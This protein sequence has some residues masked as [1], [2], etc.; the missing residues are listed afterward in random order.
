[1]KAGKVL[2]KVGN[3]VI[4]LAVCGT[5]CGCW[6][7]APAAKAQLP[8]PKLAPGVLKVIPAEP[9][10][11]DTASGPRDFVEVLR[12]APDWK[13]NYAAESETLAGEAAT[14]TFRRS[15]WQLEFAF[16][17]VRLLQVPVPNIDG[18]ATA[19]NI[20][21]L[22]YRIRNTGGGLKPIPEK[23]EFGHDRFVLKEEKKELR[24]MPVF[25]L[26]C[27]EF[28][29]TYADRVMPDVLD[30][31]HAIEIRDPR[32]KLYDS[33]T[34]TEMPIA[35]TGESVGREYWGVAT[36]DNVDRRTDFF[37]VYVQGLT[38]AYRWEDDESNDQGGF[39]AGRKYRFRTLKLNFYRPGDAVHE[40][41]GEFRFGLPLTQGLPSGEILD[42]YQ[43]E[44]PAD[45]TWV[46]RP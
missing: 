40:D 42:M 14:T 24:F 4:R 26:E 9:S 17:P 10:E 13:P 16:K 30:R 3:I 43:M 35:T 15:I 29:K 22:I 19:R 44:E 32:V 45:F 25:L 11:E 34:I 38:N 39:A 6:G 27:H 33:V 31:I 46:Y 7:L 36:W 23:D 5:L 18:T 1:M 21:Y 41:G 20:W 12:V 37:S 28:G 8:M 2:V